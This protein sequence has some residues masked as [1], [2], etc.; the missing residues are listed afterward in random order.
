V[1]HR[2][3]PKAFE[4]PSMRITSG[5]EVCGETEGFGKVPCGLEQIPAL[6]GMIGWLRD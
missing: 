4:I 5:G 3:P 2:G 1:E 6:R